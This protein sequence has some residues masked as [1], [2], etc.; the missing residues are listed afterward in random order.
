MRYVLFPKTYYQTGHF[1][2]IIAIS[3]Y[4]YWKFFV[5]GIVEQ[6][7]PFIIGFRFWKGL[8]KMPEINTGTLSLVDLFAPDILLLAKYFFFLR[9]VFF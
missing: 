5:H 3:K 6:N 4:M 9:Y 1:K 8:L 2:N 7:L